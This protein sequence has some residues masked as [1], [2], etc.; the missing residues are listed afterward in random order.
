MQFSPVFYTVRIPGILASVGSACLRERSLHRSLQ[1]FAAG[2]FFSQTARL[3]TQKGWPWCS[4]IS[5]N[6]LTH[7]RTF[8]HTGLAAQCSPLLTP[9]GF[10]HFFYKLFYTGMLSTAQCLQGSYHRNDHESSRGSQWT[11]LGAVRTRPKD[12]LNPDKFPLILYVLN[13]FF[14]KILCLS[15]TLDILKTK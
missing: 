9:L 10:F 5:G 2:R 13:I 8:P 6:T 14:P 7:V 11:M 1:R 3:R 15:S 12:G 4:Q